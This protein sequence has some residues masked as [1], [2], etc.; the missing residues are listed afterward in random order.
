MIKIYLCG[1]IKKT[2]DDSKIVW[3]GDDKEEIMRVLPE[4]ELLDPQRVPE[5]YDP[6]VNFGCDIND[7]K[8]ADFIMVDARQKR[9]IGIGAEMAIAKVWKKPVVT[10]CPRNSHFRR[11]IEL[12]GKPL[13]G[14]IHPFLA[15]LSDEVVDDVKQAAIWV[16]T[17]SEDGRK[18]KDEGIFFEAIDSFKRMRGSRR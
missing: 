3:S 14:W 16:S 18:A 4:A 9:G 2:A 17:F 10:V 5:G 6:L 13:K 7:I 12:D 15:S 1:G 8:Q 11:D